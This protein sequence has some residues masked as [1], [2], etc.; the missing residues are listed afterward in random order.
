MSSAKTTPR[1]REISGKLGFVK[2]YDGGSTNTRK[3]K[4][5]GRQRLKKLSNKMSRAA[6]KKDIA[7]SV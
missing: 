3:S 2:A 4:M 6:A 1:E 5:K 7:S